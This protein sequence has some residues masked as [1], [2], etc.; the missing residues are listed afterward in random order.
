LS[1]RHNCFEKK[2]KKDKEKSFEILEFKKPKKNTTSNPNPDPFWT[3][4]KIEGT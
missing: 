4:F 3:H 2:S 1:G